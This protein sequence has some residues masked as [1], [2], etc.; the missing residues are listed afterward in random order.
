MLKKLLNWESNSHTELLK[1]LFLI[2]ELFEKEISELN[3]S[4]FTFGK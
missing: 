2:R 4:D 1:A 3:F